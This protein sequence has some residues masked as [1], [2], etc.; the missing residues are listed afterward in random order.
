MERRRYATICG[1]A[2]VVVIAL[3]IWWKVGDD[4][5]GADDTAP[6]PGAVGADKRFDRA[7]RGFRA[8]LTRMATGAIEGT[9]RDLTGSPVSAAQVCGSARSNDIPIDRIR[10]P[11]CTTAGADGRY[12]LSGLLPARYS[13]AASAPRFRPGQYRD[14]K[15]RTSLQLAPGEERRGIDIVLGSGGVEL[16]GIVKDIGGGP[17]AAAWVRAAASGWAGGAAAQAQTAADGRFRLWVAP[18]NAR[19]LTQADGYTDGMDIATAPGQTVEILLT[20][21]SSLAGRVV[22]VGSGAPVPGARVTTAV[23]VDWADPE[24][25]RRSR[26]ATVTDEQGRFHLDR[27]APGQYELAATSPHGYG[28]AR[29]SVLLGLAQNVDEVLIELHP[30]AS[31]IG[32]VVVADDESPCP[33]G[34]VGLR[35]PDGERSR[36]AT[37]DDGGGVELE[38][39]LPGRYRVQVEC[40]GFLADEAYPDVV[41][42]VSA[43]PAEQR[44]N[45]RAGARIRGTVRTATGTAVAQAEILARA[46]ATDRTAVLE[47]G[48]SASSAVDG[49]FELAGLRAGTYELMASPKD[50]PATTHPDPV[51]LSE[52]GEATVDI[53][54]D[55]GGD[56][57]GVVVDERGQPLPRLTVR[58]FEI[59]KHR[60]WKLGQQGATH[61]ADDGTFAFHGLRPG[62]YQISASQ[63]GPLGRMLRAPGAG[64]DDDSGK[65]VAVAAGRQSR[66]RLVVESQSGV[67]RGRVVGREGAISDAFVDAHRESESATA[68]PGRAREALR[69]SRRP[70]L[71]DTDGEFTFDGLSPGKYTLRAYHRGGGE[72]IVE[73][74]A[75]GATVTLTI[76]ATGSIAGALEI[77]GSAVPDEFTVALSDRQ[78]QF[79]RTERFFRTGGSF[80]LRDVPPGS[81]DVAVTAVQGDGKTTTQVAEGQSVTGVV[82]RLRGRG[83]VTGRIISLDEGK[84]LPGYMIRVASADSAADAPMMFVSGQ[85]PPHSGVDGRFVAENAPAGPVQV[86]AMPGDQPGSRHGVVR[87]AA[88]VEAGSVTDLGDVRVPPLRLRPDESA[89]DLGFRLKQDAPDVRPGEETL[90]VALIRP[91][92][93]AAQSGLKVGDVIVA[94]DGHDVRGDRTSYWTFSR[95]LPGTTVTFGLARGESVRITA[96]EAR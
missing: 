73:G 64:D 59:G 46:Q 71:T 14:A 16:A 13:V 18:G 76:P 38:G 79:S 48:P 52:G 63:G 87:R 31:V 77:Q 44:W 15:R 47:W 95:V 8:D 6:R 90:V 25:S 57:A 91:D 80:T 36:S 17:I 33:S 83:T 50:H 26:V 11:I 66:V 92:G 85:E 84:P 1:V 68:T 78:S 96:A 9:V 43:R 21:E 34:W 54:L 65:R 88:E 89:G 7:R 51:T 60:V 56:V 10:D 86:T 42:A 19:L 53:R 93:P 22:E 12:R 23:G 3:A 27:L 5:G 82:I 32:R 45:V 70:V 67:I 49:S 28:Q 30:A 74:V 24:S 69:W 55:R 81:F 75:I 41:V 72:A 4:G 20:P 39:L 62:A 58:A 37:L 2:V 61:T 94:V 40:D 29:G 35:D